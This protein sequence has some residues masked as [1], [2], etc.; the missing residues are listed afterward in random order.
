MP[1]TARTTKS[2]MPISMGVDG[3]AFGAFVTS[4]AAVPTR[5]KYRR[6]ISRKR[7]AALLRGANPAKQKLR[8]HVMPPRNLG[9]RNPGIE[10]L[11]DHAEPIPAVMRIGVA[12]QEIAGGGFGRALKQCDRA[13]S[14]ARAS[15][16]R[17]SHSVVPSGMPSSNPRPTNRVNV[18][19][20]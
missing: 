8:A 14:P 13:Y 2:L 1:G 4:V 16:S 15:F 18:A 17:K 5:H 11:G 7:Q 12:H 10:R 20:S 3:A 19:R 6:L 9:N